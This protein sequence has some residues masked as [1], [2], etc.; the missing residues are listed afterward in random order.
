MTPLRQRLIE[1]LKLRNYAPGT[2]EAYV[3]AVAKLARHFN[4][5]PECLSVE[6]IRQFQL[7][8]MQ[9]RVSWSQFNQVTSGLRFFF[10]ITLG[11]PDLVPRIPYGRRSKYLPL[12]LAP[13]EVLQLFGGATPGRDRVLLQTTYA[14]GLRVSAVVALEISAIDSARGVVVIRQ[15]KGRKDRLVPLSARLLEELRHYWQQHRPRP[16]LFPGKRPGQALC[17]AAAQKVCRRAA[18]RAGLSKPLTM[19]TLR[20]SYA[21]HL[22]EA[23]CD[24][25]TI[26]RLLGH[27]DL[28]TTARYLHVSTQRLQQ[29]PSLLDWVA[30]PAA[31]TPPGPPEPLS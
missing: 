16:W 22:L 27:R 26:Q 6:Q 17:I 12:I 14:C 24:L 21:T 8:L 7:H 3:A 28:K 20:H 15:G 10:G 2:I 23:G 30:Q 13:T 31:P 29:T 19:H 18:Q 25:V 4:T 11:H 5:S 1:D 9:Q